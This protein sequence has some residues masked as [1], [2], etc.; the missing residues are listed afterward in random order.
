MSSATALLPLHQQF[1][2]RLPALQLR[3]NHF[4]VLLDTLQQIYVG[5]HRETGP[6]V[7]LATPALGQ[8]ITPSASTGDATYYKNVVDD[9]TRAS[10]ALT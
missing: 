2:R 5:L 6:E 8:V 1:H 9:K 10:V 3:D 7:V 4:G